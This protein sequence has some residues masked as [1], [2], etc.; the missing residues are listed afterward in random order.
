MNAEL[1]PQINEIY[2]PKLFF[3]VYFFLPFSVFGG[4]GTRARFG[5]LFVIYSKEFLGLREF[6]LFHRQRKHYGALDAAQRNRVSHKTS[7][8]ACMPGVG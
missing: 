1:N 6:S 5:C 8:L 7:I 4:E 3:C 2:D